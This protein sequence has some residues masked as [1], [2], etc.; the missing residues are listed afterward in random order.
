MSASSISPL[1]LQQVGSSR[2]I[3][4][5]LLQGYDNR[6]LFLLHSGLANPFCENGFK[7]S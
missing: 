7:R 2:N 5:L 3:V 1:L 6:V 4:Q